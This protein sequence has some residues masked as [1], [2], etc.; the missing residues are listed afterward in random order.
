MRNRTLY[1]GMIAALVAVVAVVGCSKKPPP[2]EVIPPPEVTPSEMPPEQ[3]T[4]AEETAAPGV[5]AE[6]AALQIE[7]VFFEFDKY[8]LTARARTTLTRNADILLAYPDLRVLVEGHCDE[9][10]TRE[11]NLALGDRRARAA[12]DF[13]VAYGIDA[14]RIETISYGEERP[15][16]LGSTEN[17][18]S[19]NRRAHLVVR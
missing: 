9:R 4:P 2:G 3:Q 19:K 13:L 18:W 5:S 11:Y 7:D 16:V 6:E 15:F 12:Q 1:W 14:G 8:A 10:G 17:A